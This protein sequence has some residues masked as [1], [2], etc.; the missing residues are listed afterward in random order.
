MSDILITKGNRYNRIY[1][2]PQTDKGRRWIESNFQ[3]EGEG[4]NVHVCMDAEHKEDIIQKLEEEE[5]EV[6]VE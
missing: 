2:L 5:L 6:Y 1:L 4:M 3:Y